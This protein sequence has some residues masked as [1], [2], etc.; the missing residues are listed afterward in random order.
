MVLVWLWLLRFMISEKL[1]EAFC[2]MQAHGK[3]SHTH[4]L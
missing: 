4:R 3:I 1:H 2:I